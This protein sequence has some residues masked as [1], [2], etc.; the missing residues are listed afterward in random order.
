MKTYIIAG[1][2]EQARNWL[3]EKEYYTGFSYK[4]QDFQIITDVF[5]LRGIENPS[6]VFV[7]TWYQ[8]KDIR[9]ILEVLLTCMRETN[10][11]VMKALKFY[12]EYN[13]GQ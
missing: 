10:E 3:R 13:A 7:G 6:G 8:R 11:G 2:S 12:G 5:Q 1:T 9:D 4:P